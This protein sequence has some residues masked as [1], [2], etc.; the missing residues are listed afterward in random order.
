[1]WYL[2]I[3]KHEGVKS[4]LF[5][6][7]YMLWILV[8]NWTACS[9]RSPPNVLSTIMSN[10]EILLIVITNLQLIRAPILLAGVAFNTPSV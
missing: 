6:G 9:D 1:M 3:L 10:F 4:Q 7:Y 8:F 5:M 2:L